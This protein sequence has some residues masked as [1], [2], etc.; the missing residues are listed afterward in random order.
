LSRA[1]LP[2]R[3]P[4]LPL[5]VDAGLESHQL[6]KATPTSWAELDGVPVTSY[7]DADAP[8]WRAEPRRA[9]PSTSD[10]LRRLEKAPAGFA[11]YDADASPTG[12]TRSD[13]PLYIPQEIHYAHLRNPQE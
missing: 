3:R 12:D 9:S 10:V 8:E 4:Y 2:L 5:G 11:G 7:P 13:S 1:P 6:R